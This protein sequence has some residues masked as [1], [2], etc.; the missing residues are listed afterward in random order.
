M[1]QLHNFYYFF[2]KFKN[3]NILIFFFFSFFFSLR[4]IPSHIQYTYE[5]VNIETLIN[6]L[7][8]TNEGTD[9]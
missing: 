9:L 2:F 1:S 8:T 5:N 6:T 7:R 3:K 4:Y